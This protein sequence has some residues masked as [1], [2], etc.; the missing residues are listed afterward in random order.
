M[1]GNGS[2]PRVTLR[3]ARW[4]GLRYR[5]TLVVSGSLGF[6]GGPPVIGPTTS[7]VV[8]NEVLRG[9]SE[10]LVE[11]RHG[12][13][14]RLVEERSRLESVT[15]AQVG[16]PQAVLDFW[17][18]MLSPVRNTT[19]LQRV[20]ESAE[21]VQLNSELLGGIMPPEAVT[22]AIDGAI[23]QQRHVPFRLPPSPVGVG[24]RWRFRENV[25]MNG[26]RGTQ[27]AEM[28]LRN[29]DANEAVV[30]ITLRQEAPPQAISHPLLPGSKATLDAFRGEGS[31]ELVVDRLTAV[32]LSGNIAVAARS[33]M[34]AEAGDKK[35][36]ATLVGVSNILMAGTIL[37]DDFDGDTR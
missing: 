22:R 29:V 10:P 17:N 6:E 34:T 12:G 7:M 18:L 32:V 1:L 3:V 21:V 14:V 11:R 36:T 23:E 27:S 30:G 20:A 9:S 26:I 15:I 5:S 24:A 19:Y 25:T 33:T 35:N 2:D 8:E 31:G 28:T 13:V 16:V 4:S 37:R